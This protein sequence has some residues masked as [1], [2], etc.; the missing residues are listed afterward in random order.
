MVGSV[1]GQ[2]S[3][4]IARSRQSG[5]TLVSSQCVSMTG[6]VCVWD[7]L[8]ILSNVQV[9]SFQSRCGLHQIDPFSCTSQ[10]IWP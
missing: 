8:D 4:S 3:Q 9:I 1:S 2:H 5:V 7:V 10:E 6:A